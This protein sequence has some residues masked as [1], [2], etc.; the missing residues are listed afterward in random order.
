MASDKM[1]VETLA[2]LR[3]MNVQI[4]E[5]VEQGKCDANTAGRFLLQRAT[6]KL[7]RR[8]AVAA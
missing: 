3:L 5:L 2:T 6:N 8:Q 1:T 7:H 4:A